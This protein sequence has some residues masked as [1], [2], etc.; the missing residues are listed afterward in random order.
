MMETGAQY[1]P[2]GHFFK[3]SLL[4]VERGRVLASGVPGP[5]HYNPLGV[6]HGGFASTLMDLALGHVS[7][8]VLEGDSTGVGTTDLGVK[9]IR[10]MQHSV[11]IVYCEADV[12]HAGR[13]VVI[14]EARLRDAA[15]KLYATAQSTC[16]V[17]TA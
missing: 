8:T 9:Y 7:I 16:L 17:L 12:I 13:R 4:E 2:I 5:E 6:V 3:F 15:G 14:A 10:S 11:G 1:P